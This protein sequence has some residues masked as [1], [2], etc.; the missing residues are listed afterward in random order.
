ML[1]S[2]VDELLLMIMDNLPLK[3]YVSFATTTQR[4]LALSNDRISLQHRINRFNLPSIVNPNRLDYLAFCNSRAPRFRQELAFLQ[5]HASDIH[6]L[7]GDNHEKILAF[8]ALISRAHELITMLDASGDERYIQEL[9]QLLDTVNCR[10]INKQLEN[11]HGSYL[12][13]EHITRL[14]EKIITE[15]EAHFRGVQRIEL[16]DNCLETIPENL[17]VCERLCSLNLYENP[18]TYLPKNINLLENLEFLYMSNGCLRQLPDSF[19]ELSSLKWLALDSMGLEV[20]PE[21]LAK[22]QNLQWLYVSGNQ[23]S[24]LPSCLSQ[25]GRLRYFYADKNG[26][27]PVI[28]QGALKFLKQRGISLEYLLACQDKSKLRMPEDV[29]ELED[30]IEQPSSLFQY[31][32]QIAQRTERYAALDLDIGSLERAFS[33]M[34]LKQ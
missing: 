16:K 5:G 33:K 3:D 25:M 6:Q 1:G 22:L 27:T 12:K 23:L 24:T 31:Q 9:N 32:Q 30:L 19:F 28:P 20:L 21:N 4:N 34:G 8:N 11:Q 7:C 13:L 17:S 14:P 29:T 10:I 18:I 15:N 26:L 2:L